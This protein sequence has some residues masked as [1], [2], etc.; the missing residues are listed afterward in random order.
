MNNPKIAY[1]VGLILK[2]CVIIVLI[3][4]ATT[5]QEYNYYTF[6]RW[7]VMVTFIY[8]SYRAYE[9]GYFGLFIFFLAV[10]VIF[11]SFHKITFER[12]TWHLIDY[13]VAI[14]TVAI[15]IYDVRGQ[16]KI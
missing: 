2:V 15:I 16:Q 8:F 1:S 3:V 6:L 9:K 7:F 10:A 12:G 11:N 14:F 13:L 4:G 5:K